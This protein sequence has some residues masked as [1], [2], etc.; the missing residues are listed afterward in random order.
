VCLEHD[1]PQEEVGHHQHADPHIAKDPGRHK[2]QAGP[3]PL[4]EWPASRRRRRLAGVVMVVAALG[5][6][7]AW[8]VGGKK[9][10]EQLGV[11]TQDT[12]LI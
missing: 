11:F 4:P 10:F 2:P 1:G 5:P 6:G 7:G 8:G 3:Q 12:A 9:Q